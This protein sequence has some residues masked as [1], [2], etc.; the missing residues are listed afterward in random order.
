MAL[1]V[2]TDIGGTFTDIAVCDENGNIYVFKSPTVP[3]NFSMGVIGAVEVAARFRSES[4]EG[5]L[6]Q[7]SSD[8]GRFVHGSTI[9]TNAILEGKV[10]KVGLICTRGHRDILTLREGAEKHNPYHWR[11]KYTEPYVPRYL[12]ME[13]TERMSAEGDVL[14]PLV[15]DDV[16]AA[17]EQLKQYKVDAI[18]VC[19]LWDIANPAHERRVGELIREQWPEIPVV[20]AYELNPCIRELKRTSSAAIN[21]SLIPVVGKYYQELENG[22]ENHGYS[23][24]LSI[25]NCT[26]GVMSVQEMLSKPI[27]SVDSGPTMA[28]VMGHEVAKLELGQSNLIVVDMGGTSFDISTVMDGVIPQS[29][30]AKIKNYYDLGI[31]K[32]V[33]KTIGSGGGSIAWVDAGGMLHVGPKSAGSRPGPACYG[34]GGTLPTVTDANLVLGFLNEDFYNGGAM[35]LY[36]ELAEQAIMEHVGKPLGLSLLDAAYSI[37]HT[38]NSDMAVSVE[39]VTVWEGV[40]PRNYPLVAGGGAAGLHITQICMQ[41]GVK[42]AILPKVAGAL[43]AAGGIYAD[44]V[45]DYALGKFVNTSDFNYKEVNECL[46]TL[47]LWAEQFFDRLHVPAARRKIELYCEARYPYQVVELSVPLKVNRFDDASQLAQL[48]EDFHHIHERVFGTKEETFIECINWRVR[49]V[50]EVDKPGAKPST[51]GAGDASTAHVGTRQVYLGPKIGT[52]TAE[53][54]RGEALPIG[55]IIPYDQ[56]A[57][58]EDRTTT[59][60][61]LPGCQVTVSPYENYLLDFKD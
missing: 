23:G 37:W 26:G 34:K 16:R 42:Q 44:I 6:E 31:A 53:V 20:L 4:V 2:S 22:L 49:A 61:C 50:G 18:A 54:Y 8:E 33:I 46:S 43:S 5:F 47:E 30:D 40:D 1:K 41:L 24:E 57:V 45:G 17:V 52:V 48:V 11:E 3:D 14:V 25:L 58:I 27:Y 36:P 39:E 15:E 51:R 38:V 7:C 60:L 19:L 59:F 55:S 9:T 12:T 28:P 10:G 32:S 56:V 13:V 29:R 21:A 35:K